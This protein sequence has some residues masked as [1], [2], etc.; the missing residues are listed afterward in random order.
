MPV[1]NLGAFTKQKW[2]TEQPHATSEVFQK[3]WT[4][5]TL[6]QELRL[7]VT[8]DKKRRE[9]QVMSDLVRRLVRHRCSSAIRHY[10]YPQRKQLSTLYSLLRRLI[11]TYLRN[12]KI[13]MKSSKPQRESK[14]ESLWRFYGRL[15]KSV[16]KSQRH[17]TSLKYCRCK[18]K[19]KN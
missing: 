9:I 11:V 5:L 14:T 19:W 7:S 16:N 12:T 4:L 3:L 15:K 17:L 10:Y 2:G 8:S 1:P 6:T 13:L 18:V